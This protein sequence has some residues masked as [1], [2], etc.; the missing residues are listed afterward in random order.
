MPLE[1]G[2][3]GCSQ[4]LATTQPVPLPGDRSLMTSMMLYLVW[5]LGW[6]SCSSRDA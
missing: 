1:P 6:A 2:V 4:L 5:V 3:G